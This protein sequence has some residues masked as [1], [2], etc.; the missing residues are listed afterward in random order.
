MLN[1]QAKNK[2]S[3]GLPTGYDINEPFAMRYAAENYFIRYPQAVTSKYSSSSKLCTISFLSA[4]SLSPCTAWSK[5][6]FWSTKDAVTALKDSSLQNYVATD[7][8]DDFSIKSYTANKVL[9]LAL[10]KDSVA[11]ESDGEYLNY[12][13]YKINTP[14]LV[15]ETIL[16]HVLRLA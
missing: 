15:S 11:Y 2:F 12:L 6:I 7:L 16:K 4:N 10:H 9:S 8:D 13:I 14:R 3:S 5:L 1:L